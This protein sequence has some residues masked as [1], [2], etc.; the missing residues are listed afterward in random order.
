M[1]RL[2]R[3]CG[4]HNISQPYRPPRPV[5]GIALWASTACYKELHFY[6]LPDIKEGQREEWYK[7]TGFEDG[8]KRYNERSKYYTAVE[9][10]SKEKQQL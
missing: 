3:R 7:D 5:T 4:I 2:S 1:S 9:K 10:S 8:N 6:I